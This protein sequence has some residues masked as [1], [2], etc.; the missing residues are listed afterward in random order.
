M[1]QERE[2]IQEDLR[3]LIA[4]DVHCDDLFVQMYASDASIFEIQPLGVVRPRFTADVV[5]CV[6]YAAANAVILG[7]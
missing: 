6:Q 4:G 3:G 7:Y 1:D 5:A 2:R